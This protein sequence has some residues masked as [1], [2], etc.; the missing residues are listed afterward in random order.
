[1]G[2]KAVSIVD[3][4]MAIGPRKVCEKILLLLS[5]NLLCWACNDAID[6]TKFSLIGCMACSSSLINHFHLFSL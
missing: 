6:G 4:E 1:L 3:N 2:F 5:R